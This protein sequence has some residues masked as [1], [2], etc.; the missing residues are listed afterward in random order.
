MKHKA[1][2]FFLR[3]AALLVFALSFL[4]I[5]APAQRRRLERLLD[6]LLVEADDYERQ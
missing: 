1:K 4:L 2:Q 6:W 3:A 5:G